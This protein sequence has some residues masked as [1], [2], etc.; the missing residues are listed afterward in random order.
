M[1][2][3]TA[4]SAPL[5]LCGEIFFGSPHPTCMF[6]LPPSSLPPYPPQRA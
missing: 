4:I 3:V 5:R 6:R 1:A 2:H